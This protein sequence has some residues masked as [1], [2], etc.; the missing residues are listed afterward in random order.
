MRNAD[1]NTALRKCFTLNENAV[2]ELHSPASKPDA[3]PKACAKLP[4]REIFH[5]RFFQKVFSLSSGRKWPASMVLLVKSQDWLLFRTLKRNA[6]SLRKTAF[7][8]PAGDLGARPILVR[9]F[10]VMD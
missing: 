5:K 10:R 2:G 9:D 8:N 7:T 1:T 3:R 6:P 4:R